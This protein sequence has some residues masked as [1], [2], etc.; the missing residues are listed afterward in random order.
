MASARDAARIIAPTSSITPRTI[1][2]YTPLYEQH[3]R[4]ASAIINLKGVARAMHYSRSC[5][6]APGGA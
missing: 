2:K 6:G 5:G 3:V 4:D 1:M